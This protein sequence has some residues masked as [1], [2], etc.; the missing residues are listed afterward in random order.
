MQ[1]VIT[2]PLESVVPN[3]EASTCGSLFLI[4]S[5]LTP[6]MNFLRAKSNLVNIRSSKSSSSSSPF[7]SV[8]ASGLYVSGFTSSGCES[9]SCKFSSFLSSV[10]A[11]IFLRFLPLF[12]TATTLHSICTYLESKSVPLNAFIFSFFNASVVTFLVVASYV[13][14][15]LIVLFS[16]NSK[17][18]GK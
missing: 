13:Q 11:A 8:G 7:P 16:T 1:V 17:P 4:V 14:I 2:F 10:I 18:S 3:L 12:V 9:V 6:V 15:S 5:L